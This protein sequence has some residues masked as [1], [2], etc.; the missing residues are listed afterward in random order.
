MTTQRNWSGSSPSKPTDQTYQWQ[1]DRGDR[2]FDTP[3]RKGRF[4][5]AIVLLVTT[6]MLG[7]LIATLPYSPDKTPCFALVSGGYRA[8]F[9]VNGWAED[10]LD[11]LKELDGENLAVHRVS[12]SWN[13]IT[14]GLDQFSSQ[15]EDHTDDVVSCGAAIVYLNA[16]GLVNDQGVPCILP[17]DANPHDTST[18]VPLDALFD[19][20][21]SSYPESV[22]LLVVVDCARVV[23]DW[24]LGVAYNAFSR[25][26]RDLLDEK[27]YSNFSVVASASDGERAWSDSNFALRLLKG[28]AGAADGYPNR[29]SDARV[30][31]SE[32]YAYIR[33]GVERWAS[34]TRG[35][36]QTPV[37][38]NPTDTDFQITIG[39]ASAHAQTVDGRRLSTRQVDSPVSLAEITQLWRDIGR[40]ESQTP[41]LRLDPIGLRNVHHDLFRLEQLHRAGPSMAEEARETFSDLR[42]R[43][44]HW[45]NADWTSLAGQWEATGQNQP[46][47]I[48]ELQA[49]SHSIAMA[50][51]IGAI[52]PADAN[53]LTD[54]MDSLIASA[55]GSQI[56]SP[57]TES[58]LQ[59]YAQH[60]FLRIAQSADVLPQWP[61]KIP[62]DQS[63]R[64]RRRSEQ[65]AVP[66]VEGLPDDLRAHFEVLPMLAAADQSVRDMEDALW[67]GGESLAA[68]DQSVANSQ[69]LQDEAEQALG[70]YRWAY[71]LS[72]RLS[73]DLPMIGQWLSDDYL[74][75]H[76]NDFRFGADEGY[77]RLAD[78]VELTLEIDDILLREDN[79]ELRQQVQEWT[80]LVGQR[81]GQ[82]RQRIAEYVGV[83]VESPDDSVSAWN[84]LRAVQ[85]L[86]FLSSDERQSLLAREQDIR[87]RLQGD[88]EDSD[89]TVTIDDSANSDSVNRLLAWA[90]QTAALFLL[91][92]DE[93]IDISVL[94][95]SKGRDE[96]VDSVN[97]RLRRALLEMSRLAA[98][99]ELVRDESG[100]DDPVVQV[101]AQARRVR[102]AASL[103]FPVP[104]PDVLRT[105]RVLSV[106]RWIL[107]MATRAL[108]DC[109]GNGGGIAVV[110]SDQNPYFATVAS[111][112]IAAAKSLKLP[113][114]YSAI[115]IENTE[116][117]LS[118]QSLVAL[119]GM[120][121]V[122]EDVSPSPGRGEVAISAKFAWEQSERVLPAGIATLF[123]RDANGQR[124]AV[125]PVSESVPLQNGS[126]SSSLAV[127]LR[128]GNE[129]KVDLTTQRSDRVA[130]NID[131]LAFYRGLE[132][133]AP[134]TVRT[135]S[136]NQ[137]VFS[138][139]AYDRARVTLFGDA[140][141]Q[142][143][144]VFIL[145]CSASMGDPVPSESQFSEPKSKL[146]VAKS[147]LSS[148]LNELGR[149]ESARVGVRFFGHRLGWSTTSPL[150][151]LS[152]PT[153]A[154]PA[155]QTRTP[156]TDVE[157]ILP[158]GRFDSTEAA[159]VDRRMDEVIPWGQ[160]PLHLA[161]LESMQDF[162][163][164]DRE[165]DQ[166]IVVITDGVNYQFTPANQVAV[167]AA[168]TGLETLLRRLEGS[169]VPINILGFGV[170]P[171][172]RSVAAEAFNA[173][174]EAT[175][176]RYQT[177]E[178]GRDLLEVLQSRLG[179]GRYRVSTIIE[180]DNPLRL[181]NEESH[182]LNR[183]VSVP[184][185]PSRPAP[186]NL[187][188]Q[189]SQ[190]DVAFFGGEWLQLRL[191]GN[192]IESIPY[193]VD[194]SVTEELVLGRFGEDANHVVRVHRP[195][196]I[197]EA[198]EF[199]VSMQSIDGVQT[200]R[201]AEVWVEV[202]PVGEGM[203]SYHF[204]D[205]H[206]QPDTPVPVLVWRAEN[207]PQDI[208]QARVRFW[209]KPVATPATFEIDLAS[210]LAEN[211]LDGEIPVT[212]FP[213]VRFRY[214]IQDD[215]METGGSLGI[216]IS[217]FHQP[218]SAGVG[219]LKSDIRSVVPVSQVI[220][221]FDH[222]NQIATHTFRFDP[223]L[224]DQVL[225]QP[226]VRLVFTSKSDID[227]ESW[228]MRNDAVLVDIVDESGVFPLNAAQPELIQTPPPAD[229]NADATK[230]N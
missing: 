86:P 84:E 175:G 40:L 118:Q 107:W 105:D 93:S 208:R 11:L 55:K 205:A 66:Y 20:L 5:F 61:S 217:E 179:L 110:G 65:I 46:H 129:V 12:P 119:R 102:R 182:P 112:Y 128:T 99:T 18:W 193:V 54:Q 47:F 227:S 76:P 63:V 204:Y 71:T 194:S 88:Y 207:W 25:R 134:V 109:W 115:A 147:M 176:G 37:L 95:A 201:P 150:K 75:R 48:A 159:K 16:H 186:A 135:T 226:N 162:V 67:M 130:G 30:T 77:G 178:N 229:G 44:Q 6:G 90:P 218:G 92:D 34:A 89:E 94:R 214:E 27:R 7:S 58:Q 120:I 146:D 143:S 132:F 28:L 203:P 180:N 113:V 163:D 191:N 202:T 4:G 124:I 101:A 164:D 36:R 56:L 19:R 117:R 189:A 133:V 198:V 97:N 127:P 138:P 70:I 209:T 215:G 83:L 80:Q 200:R 185:T 9:P 154:L 125:T 212:G 196:P 222:E 122:A 170:A 114:T 167:D 38:I 33:D 197:D 210:L 144:I 177:V 62:F 17:L 199:T 171:A 223:S 100:T 219:S 57:E 156:S 23:T 153:A 157:E 213:G 149:G 35:V 82:F 139:R 155:D 13:S 29:V 166:G 225:S 187:S 172:E 181:Q 72:D 190:A 14:E 141:Q 108:D 103:S 79:P 59:S 68:F 216:R 168:P 111:D 87:R 45:S 51:W 31:T 151:L 131:L 104:E 224:R 3:R 49:H 41:L 69:Q 169:S 211:R 188:F 22:N 221:Y 161:I 152:S 74:Q 142:S 2:S 64:T 96:L 230:N 98:A 126:P 116:Q 192:R 174:A 26:L 148:L 121:G 220:R 160:S 1:M 53:R 158:L 183:T 78:L 195:R 206:F 123:L 50:R 184:L 106:R 43:V 52:S 39:V 21:R 140:K 24:D 173:I 145:D 228:Q 136:G 42:N 60:Q 91:P 137:V 32:L 81:Y 73:Y 8:P 15:L 165:A 10:D 85:K